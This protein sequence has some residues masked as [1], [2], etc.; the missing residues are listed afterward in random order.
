[1]PIDSDQHIDNERNRINVDDD[2]QVDEWATRFDVTSDQI[3]VAVGIVGDH[4]DDVEMHLKGSRS[5]SNA[6]RQADS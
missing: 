6:D 2:A 4:A 5:S 1:M 3:K